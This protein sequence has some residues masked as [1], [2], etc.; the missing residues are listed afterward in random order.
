MQTCYTK[1]QSA[2]F[3][4]VAAPSFYYLHKISKAGISSN[5]LQWRVETKG[6]LLQL[7]AKCYFLSSI[8]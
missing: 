5:L 3:L 1:T 8:G 4:H 2:S 7:R 6:R